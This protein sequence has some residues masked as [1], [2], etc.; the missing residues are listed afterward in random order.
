MAKLI[1]PVLS[2]HSFVRWLVLLV[3]VIA[4]VKFA[5]GW[6]RGGEFKGI[7]GGL[8]AAYNGF[9][10]L[11]A[12]LGL[13]YFFWTGFTSDGFPRFRFE[14]AFMMLLALIA[15]HLPSRWKKADSKTRFRNSLFAILAS[16]GFILI[17]ISTLPGGL[18]R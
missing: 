10:Y 14:H 11:Q 16:I 5:V 1:H 17:G 13:I 2:I 4:V 8:T 12:K 18:S 7:D 15:G 3:A 9:I 6:L